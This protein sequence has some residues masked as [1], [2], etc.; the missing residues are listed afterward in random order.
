MNISGGE[1]R[2]LS[3]QDIQL[4]QNRIQQ[5]LQ[6]YMNKKEVIN[7]LIIQDNIEPHFTELVASLGAFWSSGPTVLNMVRRFGDAFIFIDVFIFDA[8][9]L[10]IKGVGTG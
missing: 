10:K 9:D 7:A 3:D 5:C 1:A 2:K 4:V 8:Q 6:H